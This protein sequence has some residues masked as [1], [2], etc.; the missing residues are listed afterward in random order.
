MSL[1]QRC[2]ALSFARQHGPPP[3]P[4]E[5]KSGTFCAKGAAN[6][7]NESVRCSEFAL[8]L[9]ALRWGVLALPVLAAYLA[10]L[11]LLGVG[12]LVLAAP[13]FQDFTP[14]LARWARPFD[15]ALPLA[16]ALCLAGPL[17]EVLV[18]AAAANR[19][20]LEQRRRWTRVAEDALAAAPPGGEESA[21]LL[22][23]AREALGTSALCWPGGRELGLLEPFCLV[24][25]L[26]AVI[27][28]LAAAVLLPTA[29]GANVPALF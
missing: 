17:L 22:P 15:P 9:S 20:V 7:V 14:A 23:L 26:L 28:A 12:L 10:V 11:K 8:E 2:S 24:L 4:A 16:V 6:Y 5:A 21:A 13:H 18:S 27:A 25:V 29:P 1:Q 19:E 3:L